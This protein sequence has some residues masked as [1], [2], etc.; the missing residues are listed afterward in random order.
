MSVFLK[1]VRLYK[2]YGYQIRTGLF[3]PHFYNFA[4]AAGT[5]IEKDAL[6]L[7]TGGGIGMDEVHLIEDLCAVQ[8]PRGVFII[9]NAF[10]WS[11]FAF[12]YAFRAPVLALDAGLEGADNMVGI[13]L[14]NH[15]AEQEHLPVWCIYGRSPQ[16]VRATLA[17][18]MPQLPD[19][20]FIDGLHTNIQL[21]ADF[22][23]TFAVVPQATFL[24]HDIVNCKMQA[25][26]RQICAALAPTHHT[27]I[28]TRTFSGM[29]LAIPKARLNDFHW[30][31][32]AYTDDQG[33][34]DSVRL[35]WRLLQI[36]SRFGVL[37]KLGER[38][39]LRFDKLLQLLTN[40]L[41]GRRLPPGPNTTTLP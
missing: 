24:F 16:D 18:H 2:E 27:C 41:S 20:I 5:V 35:R 31:L 17:D 4:G 37:G 15:I 26:F 36:Q 30:L 19:L 6:K 10:G 12:A 11:S 9:G 38:L 34:I 33:Y 25:A 32:E 21:R 22:D 14:T 29:G 23:A 1:L 8:Q 39:W 40:R 13:K 7:R 3:P 28:L